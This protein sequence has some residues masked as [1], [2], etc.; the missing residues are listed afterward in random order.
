MATL[1]ETTLKVVFNRK[2]FG[3]CFSASIVGGKGRLLRLI[4]DGT[5]R[6]K[7]RS[8]A[9]NGKLYCNAWDVI[10]CSRPKF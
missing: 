10:K 4:E 1:D 5:I 3:M 6:A 9:P 7:K 8:N 2:T